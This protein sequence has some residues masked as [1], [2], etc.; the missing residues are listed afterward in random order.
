MAEEA[1][2]RAGHRGLSVRGNEEK[3]SRYLGARYTYFHSRHLSRKRVLREDQPASFV[4]LNVLQPVLLCRATLHHRPGSYRAARN[5]ALLFANNSRIMGNSIGTMAGWPWFMARKSRNGER[6]VSSSTAPV[7]FQRWPLNAL[8]IIA[9]L[10][11]SVPFPSF[12]SRPFLFFPG[13]ASLQRSLPPRHYRPF[14]RFQSAL[15]VEWG[16]LDRLENRVSFFFSFFASVLLFPF[17][18]LLFSRGA[19]LRGEKYRCSVFSRCFTWLFWLAFSAGTLPMKVNS[20][21]R[22]EMSR[23]RFLLRYR[24]HRLTGVRPNRVVQI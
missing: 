11:P 20:S 5:R 4:T 7:L 14:W 22:V 17:L 18:F 12:L 2:E 6:I 9:T 1:K 15:G 23:L 8:E 19:L 16:S 21:N 13:R 24:V 10:F 3:S